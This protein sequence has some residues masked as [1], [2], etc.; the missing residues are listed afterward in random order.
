M[1][2]TQS[3]RHPHLTKTEAFIVR[4]ILAGHT[5]AADLETNFGFSRRTV[6]THLRNIFRTTGARNKVD[7]VLMALG[8]RKGEIDVVAQLDRFRRSSYL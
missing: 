5:T 7:L 8:H 3:G 4:A 1:S 6:Q 2:E